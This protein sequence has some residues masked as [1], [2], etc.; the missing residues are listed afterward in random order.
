[1]WDDLVREFK[2][3]WPKEKMV[4]VTVKQRRHKLRKEVMKEEDME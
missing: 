4:A 3:R 2:K 1:M